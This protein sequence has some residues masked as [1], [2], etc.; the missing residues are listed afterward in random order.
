MRLLQVGVV[1][2]ASGFRGLEVIAL[3][4]DAGSEPIVVGLKE[5]F[6][7]LVHEG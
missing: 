6:T 7:I 4:V 1:V 5:H 3:F 2:S